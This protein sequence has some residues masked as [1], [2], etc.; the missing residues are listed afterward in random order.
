MKIQ[1]INP[2]LSLAKKINTNAKSVNLVT[3]QSF[4]GSY[5]SVYKKALNES[6]KSYSNAVDLYKKL[7]D[8]AKTEKGLFKGSFYRF[9]EGSVIEALKDAKKMYSHSGNLLTSTS[10]K[11]PLVTIENGEIS[12]HH[13]EYGEFGNGN[14]TFSITNNNEICVSRPKD[15]HRFYEYGGLKEKYQVYDDGSGIYNHKYYNR[16]GSENAIKNF[17]FGD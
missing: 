10:H 12:F 3:Q 16:D 6:F 7:A 15:Y 8:S 5:F 9:L 11:S 1:Q 17:F 14:I 13:P 4:K 2:N